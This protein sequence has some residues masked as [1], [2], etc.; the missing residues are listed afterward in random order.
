MKHYEVSPYNNQSPEKLKFDKRVGWLGGAILEP[1]FLL[2]MT[3]LK[4]ANPKYSAFYRD[5][6]RIGINGD[7]FELKK[8]QTLD[9]NGDFLR[10]GKLARKGLDELP[11]LD[12]LRKGKDSPLHAVGYRAL[13]PDD[14]NLAV[15]DLRTSGA[16]RLVEPWMQMRE[17]M[18]P[19]ITGPNQTEPTKNFGDERGRLQVVVSN[20]LREIHYMENAS[21]EDDIRI[22]MRTF[23]AVALDHAPSYP[24]PLDD[25][26]QQAA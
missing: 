14:L 13:Q 16:E 18:K 8:F 21:Q 4:I 25:Q 11:Q 23:G 1:L 15:Q 10:L 19:G 2:T 26:N 24:R 6:T 22:L 9:E 20:V 7:T 17:Q 5:P 3:S 12:L